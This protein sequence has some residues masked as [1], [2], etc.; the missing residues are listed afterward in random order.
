MS[1]YVPSLEARLRVPTSGFEGY[2]VRSVN[3]KSAGTVKLIP[4]G[5]DDLCFV[6]ATGWWLLSHQIVL[7]F[8]C[9]INVESE[10]KTVL[11]DLTNDEIALAPNWPGIAAIEKIL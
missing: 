5:G 10:S 3:G 7:P 11:V 4:R 6:V 1:E 9:I 2:R 8:S